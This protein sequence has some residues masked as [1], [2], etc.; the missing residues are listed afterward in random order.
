MQIEWAAETVRLSLFTTEAVDIT[1]ADW[2]GLTGQP[3]APN[4]QSMPGRRVM[5]GPFHPGALHL[6]ALGNRLDCIL[7]PQPQEAPPLEDG[8]VSMGD[9]LAAI[10]SFVSATS[11]WLG[12][13]SR[14]VNRLAFGIV[15]ISKQES[16][17]SASQ[18]IINILQSIQKD[19]DY[20]DLMFRVNW[21]TTSKYENGI[22]LN[23]ITNWASLN[24]QM[25]LVTA[26]H[27]AFVAEAAPITIIRLEC[28]NS[29]APDRSRAI[30]RS[31]LVPIYRELVDLA[32]ENIEKGEIR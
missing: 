26:G 23:R 13:I 12:Q 18:K 4:T 17:R 19:R 15:L 9:P 21:P 20:D 28:D 1:N 32:V 8:L 2:L 10:R 5:F 16:K 29:T 30:D 7:A 25:Q 14:P 11:E 3:E 6:Q 22:L 24:I 31:N 27:Q